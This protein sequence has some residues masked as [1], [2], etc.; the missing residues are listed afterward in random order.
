MAVKINKKSEGQRRGSPPSWETLALL[1]GLLVGAGWAG[2]MV[3][4]M[5]YASSGWEGALLLVG[6]VGVG[7]VSWL[8]KS[9]A[10][11]RAQAERREAGRRARE[12]GDLAGAEKIFTELLREQA[13]SGTVA[14]RAGIHWELLSLYR[15]MKRR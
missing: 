9:Q 13:E 5:V 11:A 14:G 3:V 7:I 6:A 15:Q 12:E 10:P 2:W 1:F 8:W 4:E